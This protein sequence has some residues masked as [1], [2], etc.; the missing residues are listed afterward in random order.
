MRLRTPALLALAALAC[1]GGDASP[2]RRTLVDS[3]DREDPRSLDPAV[4]TDV[5]TGRAVGYVFD[6]QLRFT[7]GA[8]DQDTPAGAVRYDVQVYQSIP[9]LKNETAQVELVFGVGNLLRAA[10]DSVSSLYDEVLVVR[11]PTRVVGGVT[12]QF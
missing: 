5:P 4:S 9:Y 1:R 6:G 3:R 8:I 11:P 12:V 10:T 7:R 2:E